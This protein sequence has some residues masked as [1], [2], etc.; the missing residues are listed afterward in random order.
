M[1][2]ADGEAATGI[3]AEPGDVEAVHSCASC[4]LLSRHPV[5]GQAGKREAGPF[6][7]TESSHVL[8]DAKIAICCA[9]M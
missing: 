1:A 9:C 6:N 2:A 5:E 7:K 3:A 4:Y 8:G